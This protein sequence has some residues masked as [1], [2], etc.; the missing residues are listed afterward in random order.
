MQE[1]IKRAIRL[2]FSLGFLDLLEEGTS[3]FFG[4]G[5]KNKN[6]AALTGN[7]L[8]A[9]LV[10]GNFSLRKILSATNAASLRKEPGLNW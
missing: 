7:F 8:T 3:V 5:I 9:K 6:T 4:F 1:L 10:I 2:T